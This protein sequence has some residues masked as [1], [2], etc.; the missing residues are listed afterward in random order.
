[1]R[2]P[3]NNQHNTM[4]LRSTTQKLLLERIYKKLLKKEYTRNIKLDNFEDVTKPEQKTAFRNLM[5][6]MADE[7]YVHKRKR[8]DS[9]I[10]VED[11]P[12][13][14]NK[15]IGLD[16]SEVKRLEV[17]YD[18]EEPETLGVGRSYEEAEKY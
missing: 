13:K 7:N 8:V 2:E 16:E 1:M 11:N 14:Y 9:W 3:K 10:L 5:K 12:K 17:L 6:E 15:H 18:R 4:K